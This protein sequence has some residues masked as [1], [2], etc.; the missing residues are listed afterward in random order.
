MQK[1]ADFIFTMLDDLKNYVISLI[2]I[3]GGLFKID[4]DNCIIYVEII[5]VIFYCLG[6]CN[7]YFLYLIILI[8]LLIMSYQDIK[9][10]MIYSPYSYVILV[11][12]V[13]AFPI[14]LSRVIS[15]LLMPL[16]FYLINKLF[17]E[18]IGDGDVELIAILGALLGFGNL[19]GCLVL[20]ALF[21]GTYY[22]GTKDKSIPLVP[23]LT[24]GFI[25]TVILI[26]TDYICPAL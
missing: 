20:T 7:E 17:R 8:N 26:L 10:R 16:I 6:F 19:I 14:T 1:F 23:C 21:A 25:F 2:E 18:I 12:S 24:T 9:L 4:K 5:T 22:A 15:V 11:C 3:L 13:L